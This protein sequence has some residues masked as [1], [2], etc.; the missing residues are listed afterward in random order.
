MQACI[1][2]F[3][4]PLR[5]GECMPCFSFTSAN[6]RGYS[7]A[8]SLEALLIGVEGAQTPAGSAGQVRP[9]RSLRRGGSPPAPRKAKRLERK[10]TASFTLQPKKTVDKLVFYQFVYSLS[11]LMIACFLYVG[12]FQLIKETG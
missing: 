4:I 9:R 8:L 11:R 3:L 5:V 10:S 12:W 2:N 1:D 7:F 6:T